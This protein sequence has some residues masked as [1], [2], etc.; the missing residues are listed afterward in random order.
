MV[1]LGSNCDNMSRPAT[2]SNVGL[3]GEGPR[4]IRRVMIYNNAIQI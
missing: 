2:A 1:E 3:V 4:A